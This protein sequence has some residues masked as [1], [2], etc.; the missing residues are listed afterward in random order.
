MAIEWGRF[1]VDPTFI[2]PYIWNHQPVRPVPS[3]SFLS[4]VQLAPQEIWIGDWRQWALAV[5]ISAKRRA[6]RD[7]GFHAGWWTC[8]FN[9]PTMWDADGIFL[10]LEKPSTRLAAGLLKHTLHSRQTKKNILEVLHKK[11]QC[12]NVLY[13]LCWTLASVQCRASISQWYVISVTWSYI[14]CDVY[15]IQ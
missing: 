1:R 6:S 8:R 3:V 4:Q 7:G 2:H 10:K 14:C 5:W 15:S 11:S 12:F 13:L 9:L